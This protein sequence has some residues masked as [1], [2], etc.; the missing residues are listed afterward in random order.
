[1]KVGRYI[2]QYRKRIGMSQGELA[3]KSG[4]SQTYLSLIENEKQKPSFSALDEICSCFE[5]PLPLFMFMSL[6]EEDIPE[7]KRESFNLLKPSIDQ[8]VSAIFAN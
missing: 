6:S 1:M 4:L 7:G 8:L 5:I 3:Q 2:K